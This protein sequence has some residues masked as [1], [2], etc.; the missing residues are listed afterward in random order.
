MEKMQLYKI[1]NL[2]LILSVKDNSLVEVVPG[3][4]GNTTCEGKSE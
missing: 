2:H 1:Q 4:V 3:G